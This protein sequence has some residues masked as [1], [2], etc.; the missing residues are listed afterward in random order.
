MT[1]KQQEAGSSVEDKSQSDKNC[2]D[3]KKLDVT[4]TTCQCVCHSRAH[5]STATTAAK[6]AV[7]D[8]TVSP[9]KETT[10]PPP[11]A[12]EHSKHLSVLHFICS[13]IQRLGETFPLSVI[14][15]ERV[16]KIPS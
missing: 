6:P 5:I 4:N 11:P 16:V 14:L 7:V 8:L 2:G 10:Q 15:T 13:G 9:R 12:A 3:Y 1:A